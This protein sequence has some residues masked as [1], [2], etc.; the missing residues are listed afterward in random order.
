MT[1]EEHLEELMG[2]QQPITPR[3]PSTPTPS[4]DEE[5]AEGTLSPFLR[6]I[7]LANE[8][9]SQAH[10]YMPMSGDNVPQDVVQDATN[11]DLRLEY[12]ERAPMLA[13]WGAMGYALGGPQNVVPFIE[14]G[15]DF[16]EYEFESMSMYA[17]TQ[18]LELMRTAID[19]EVDAIEG[20]Y[21]EW[22]ASSQPGE[23][24][25]GGIFGVA[26]MPQARVPNSRGHMGPDPLWLQKMNAHVPFEVQQRYY[27]LKYNQTYLEA[28]SYDRNALEGLG[29]TLD[30]VAQ[31]MPLRIAIS[32]AINAAQEDRSWEWDNFFSAYSS[33]WNDTFE[34]NNQLRDRISDS[35]PTGAATMTYIENVNDIVYGTPFPERDI[36]GF[37]DNEL[38]WKRN[39]ILGAG[40]AG[41]I[42]LDPLFIFGKAGTAGKLIGLGTKADELRIIRPMLDDLGRMFGAVP[43]TLDDLAKAIQRGK[44]VSE[45]AARTAASLAATGDTPIV[46]TFAMKYPKLPEVG[47]EQWKMIEAAYKKYGTLYLPNS[48]ADQFAMKMR[49]LFNVP[50]I[51]STRTPSFWTR[52]YE[53]ATPTTALNEGIEKLGKI[54]APYGWHYEPIGSNVLEPVARYFEKQGVIDAWSFFDMFIHSDKTSSRLVRRLYRME[55]KR[56]QVGMAGGSYQTQVDIMKADQELEANTNRIWEMLTPDEQVAYES[57]DNFREHVFEEIMYANENTVV[58]VSKRRA[59][60]S[61]LTPEAQFQ[62]MRNEIEAELA[63]VINNVDN[64]DDWSIIDNAYNRYHEKIAELETQIAAHAHAPQTAPEP[65]TFETVMHD[66]LYMGDRSFIFEDEYF[67]KFVEKTRAQAHQWVMDENTAYLVSKKMFNPD[68]TEQTFESISKILRDGDVTAYVNHSMSP[69][70]REWLIQNGWVSVKGDSLKTTQKFRDAFANSNPNS[71]SQK[72]RHWKGSIADFNAMMYAKHSGDYADFPTSFWETSPTKTIANRHMDHLRRVMSSR[73]HMGMVDELTRFTDDLGNNIFHTPVGTET[74]QGFV[75]Y[76]DMMGTEFMKQF[77][78]EGQA[79]LH[80]VSVPKDAEPMLKKHISLISGR[81]QLNEWMHFAEEV[82][83]AWKI[84]TLGIFPAYHGGNLIS[85][86]YLNWLNG[87]DDVS[88]YAVAGKI[89]SGADGIIYS[90]WSG[91][92]YTYRELRQL[93]HAHGVMGGMLQHNMGD[94]TEV[95]TIM[96]GNTGRNWF[97]RQQNMAKATLNDINSQYKVAPFMPDTSDTLAAYATRRLSA[98]GRAITGWKAPRAAMWGGKGVPLSENLVD[99]IKYVGHKILRPMGGKHSVFNKFGFVLGSSIEDNARLTNF[100]DGLLNKGMSAESAAVRM[101]ET[102]FDYSKKTAAQRIASILFPFHEFKVNNTALHL[103]NVFRRPGRIAVAARIGGIATGKVDR[104]GIPEYTRDSL[105]VDMGDKTYNLSR[106]IPLMDFINVDTSSPS[107]FGMSLGE[108]I[109]E[110]ANPFVSAI[111]DLINNRDSFTGREI[112]PDVEGGN[113]TEPYKV[114]FLDT[115]MEINPQQLFWFSSIYRFIGESE[116]IARTIE[117]GTLL[118]T[119][120]AMLGLR[121]VPNSTPDAL[122]FDLKDN[123]ERLNTAERHFNEATKYGVGWGE[124]QQQVAFNNLL[125]ARTERVDLLLSQIAGG[126]MPFDGTEMPLSARQGESVSGNLAEVMRLMIGTENHPEKGL[127]FMA[128]ASGNADLERNAYIAIDST[129]N[130]R[131]A[132]EL[133]QADAEWGQYMDDDALQEYDDL[134]EAAKAS[135]K[136]ATAHLSNALDQIE[137]VMNIPNVDDLWRIAYFEK[138]VRLLDE[139]NNVLLYDEDNFDENFNRLVERNPA[140]YAIWKEW[141]TASSLND[142]RF[143]MM[144]D[145]AETTTG[146]TT[147][148]YNPG[149]ADLFKQL[150]VE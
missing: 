30:I 110:H 60:S 34:G 64:M 144:Q 71:Y 50:M 128:Q 45:E 31:T 115:F 20:Q 111:V 116:R 90:P 81:E 109:L 35:S 134:N 140:T 7:Q 9:Y 113:L 19:T 16:S 118:D 38:W 89:Q 106:Y 21:G 76:S 87:V 104:D 57:F 67:R 75:R 59:P 99:W 96:E 37:K 147:H 103:K 49:G 74:P 43:D 23:W 80:S 4:T 123:A 86:F 136:D 56:A 39:L 120:L 101:N 148:E 28:K 102:L 122:Y 66:P 2:G 145:E 3:T 149:L 55:T 143:I 62:N 73:F 1:W 79:L 53:L 125:L 142:N 32:E 72:Q 54:L 108:T 133:A 124:G 150:G 100:L 33:Y 46:Q 6:N 85:N 11:P 112:M 107:A 12:Q 132:L 14:S 48:I 42:F 65:P 127:L 105:L 91:T 61:A 26:I 139:R 52:S 114:P 15:R 129:L 63:S 97:A 8:A 58:G 82:T 47:S 70:T 13:S 126:I 36:E 93:A 40:L 146:T 69:A 138:Y 22:L 92:N 119:G 27:Q 84:D 78:E 88:K 24:V 18:E 41:D 5:E 51:R 25:F 121:E 83:N 10:G 68:E 29:R 94:V 137:R 95:Q 130:Q 135:R 77:T 17:G 98:I 131:I 141:E 44:E 117:E